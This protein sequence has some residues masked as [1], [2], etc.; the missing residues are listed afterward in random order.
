MPADHWIKD[1]GAESCS[2]CQV[3]FTLTERRHHCRDCGKL[4]C[5]KYVILFLLPLT[6]KFDIKVHFADSRTFLLLSRSN[7]LS[8]FWIM[9]LVNVL[10]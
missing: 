5:A 9:M 7:E 1:E 2:Q 3:R 6:G 8:D 10:L 4:F